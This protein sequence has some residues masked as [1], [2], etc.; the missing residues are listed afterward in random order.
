MEEHHPLMKHAFAV[1]E[2][3][4]S[5]GEVP[6]GCVIVDDNLGI[7]G[8]L[9]S[10]CGMGCGGSLERVVVGWRQAKR[11]FCTNNRVLM[12]YQTFALNWQGEV[13]TGPMNKR[14][15]LD[16]RSSKRTMKSSNRLVAM[17]QKRLS[18]CEPQPC[19]MISAA[20]EDA[21]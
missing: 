16:T 13:G 18:C 6:V 9:A 10:F 5:A 19:T 1:A 14:M 4:L 8:E 3:A 7:L 15:P 20:V 17:S 12:A 2:E 11:P 21:C